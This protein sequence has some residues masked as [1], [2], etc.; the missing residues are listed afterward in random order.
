MI[1]PR[2]GPLRWRN[3]ASLSQVDYP[4]GQAINGRLHVNL[5]PREKDKLLVAMAAVVARRR[6]ERGVK[7]NH[8]E[9]V[10]LITDY[11]VE[12][13]RDGR[14]VADLMQAGATVL[15][16]DDVMEG[17]PEMIHD[18]QVEGTFPDGT[19]LVYVGPGETAPMLWLRRF[20]RLNATPIPGT[21]GARNPFFSPDGGSIGFLTERPRALKVAS[22]LGTPPVSLSD[23]ALGTSGADWA[24]DGFIYFDADRLGLQRIP[25]GGG[26][27]EPVVPLVRDSG[28]VGVAWPHVLPGGKVVYRMRYSG[29][30][31]EAFTIN[32]VDPATGDTKTLLSAVRAQYSPSGHL[33]YAT[34][35]GQVLAAPFDP[36][37]AEIT[38][39]AMALMEGLSLGTFGVV[40]YDISSSGSMV[41]VT[42]S[43]TEQAGLFWLNLDG[44]TEPV[45]SGWTPGGRVLWLS[46]DPGGTRVALGM[47]QDGGRIDVMLKDLTGSGVPVRLTFD[48]RGNFAPLWTDDGRSILYFSDRGGGSRSVTGIPQ[49]F[50]LY[51]KRADGSGSIVPILL[52]DVTLSGGYDVTGSGDDLY[53]VL[54][55]QGSED[56]AD[57]VGFR[58]GRDSVAIPLVV[59]DGYTLD[60][61]LSPDGRWMAYRANEVNR[62]IFVRPFPN[63]EDGLW[64]VTDGNGTD[65][66]WSPDGKTIYYYGDGGTLT[67]ATVQTEPTFSVV[68]RRQ[69]SGSNAV[70]APA[71]AP[72]A[73]APDGRV[74]LVGARGG[75]SESGQLVVVQGFAEELKARAEG[76]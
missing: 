33:V 73:P 35:E 19:K 42:G 14:S 45:D 4:R 44:S 63:V 12:G 66:M 40:D 11:V 61:A 64:E 39:P 18:V 53:L 69:L 76:E 7:L 17:V 41:Y 15:I 67:A 13:A 27:R 10:A 48:G 28:E 71:G 23:T 46:L 29:S 36:R 32:V 56:E 74:L 21:E 38:G 60:P 26:P 58:P 75:G 20:D 25:E 34:A 1:G 3:G 8:P 68:E 54:T 72:Y 59:D 70:F 6:Q 49:P 31:P 2:K 9:A 57:I 43:S 50:G 51:R 22:L 37:A 65:P 24:E 16:R 52:P 62:R 47:R 55:V 5:T 30:G